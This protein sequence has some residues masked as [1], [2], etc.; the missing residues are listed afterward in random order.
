[1]FPSTAEWEFP[2]LNG[3][4]VRNSMRM[5]E[6]IKKLINDRRAGLS[7]SYHEGQIDLLDIIIEEELYKNDIDAMIDEMIVL[8]VAGMKTIQIT[9][10]NMVQY[11]TKFPE[12]KERILKETYSVI[13][14]MKDDIIEKLDADVADSF[15]FTRNCFYESMRIETPIPTSTTS[16]FN[17]EVKMG[18]VTFEAGQAFYVNISNMHH[19]PSQWQRPS[20]YL[21]DRF[22]SDSPLYATPSGE[23][24]H[25]MVFNPFL[26]GKRICL[27]KTFA[28]MTV[29]MTMP[30]LYYHF[31]FEF[32]TKDQGITKYQIGSSEDP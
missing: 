29:R 17:K 27:G 23:K 30:L 15:E 26:G 14:G 13:D 10:T 19:D 5:R 4:F 31:D 21:P 16:C 9:S 28:E 7:K 32:A 12:N 24:R 22:D 8:F 18:G 2:A 1:M 3:R 11:C 25:P 20:E 6:H